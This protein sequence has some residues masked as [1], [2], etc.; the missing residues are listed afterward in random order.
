RVGRDDFLDACAAAWTAQ[1]IAE[2]TA[3]RFPRSPDLD[4]RSLDQAIWF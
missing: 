2:R 1:R 3:S 4:R